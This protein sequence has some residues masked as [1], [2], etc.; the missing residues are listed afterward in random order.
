MQ[1]WYSILISLFLFALSCSPKVTDDDLLSK[2]MKLSDSSALKSLE[3]LTLITNPDQLKDKQKALY[4]YLFA[5]GYFSTG[6]KLEYPS[7]LSLPINYYKT[8]RD[9]VQWFESIYLLARTQYQEKFYDDCLLSL[10]QAKA[11]LPFFDEKRHEIRISSLKIQ[12]LLS[13][14]LAK[15]AEEI[16]TKLFEE[17]GEAA[18]PQDSLRGYILLAMS[19]RYNKNSKKSEE[20]YL[21]ALQIAQRDEKETQYFILQKLSQLAESIK[22]FEKA[23]YYA[24]QSESLR[25][26]R[27]DVPQRNLMKALLFYKQKLLDSAYHYAHIAIKGNDPFVA[28]KALLLLSEW[29]AKEEKFYDAYNKQRTAREIFEILEMNIVSEGYQEA[30]KKAK[31]EN[32]NNLLKIKQQRNSL[33]LAILSFCLVLMVFGIYLFS[34]KKRRKQREIALKNK[35]IQLEKDNA[36][37][38]QR[39]EISELRKKEAILRES[40]F[41][42]MNMLQKISSTTSDSSE[43]KKASRKIILT[44]KDRKELLETLNDAYPNFTQRLSEQFPLLT[45]EDIYFCCLIKISVNLQ[46]LSDIFCVTKSAITKRKYR[47]KTERLKITDASISLDSFLADF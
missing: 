24:K 37:L 12:T 34:Y 21:K 15:E 11:L 29:Y 14:N 22:D 7:I 40:L 47:I 31:L 9:T 6:R 39:Q 18:N 23:F 30:F 4:N 20:S 38:R 28:N 43:N 5:K 42:K 35:A 46:D 27:R 13:E 2:A 45:P 8:Q 3:Q 16:A 26:S 10:S 1:F 41:R 32:E 19:Q 33:F 25:M 44:E 17:L 36:I